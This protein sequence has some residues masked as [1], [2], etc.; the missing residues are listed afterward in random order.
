MDAD[1]L[2]RCLLTAFATGSVKPRSR[3]R[4]PGVTKADRRWWIPTAV[5]CD[6][7]IPKAVALHEVPIMRR[8]RKWD[9]RQLELCFE[10][11]LHA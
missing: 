8:K 1:F 5:T 4:F 3:S 9:G 11:E 10:K 2:R 7:L 6:C